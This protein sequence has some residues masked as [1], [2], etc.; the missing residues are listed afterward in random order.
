V[1]RLTGISIAICA[2][3][4]ASC[5]GRTTP[6]ESSAFGARRTTVN[7]HD[8]GTCRLVGQADAARLFHA[9]AA[10]WSVEQPPVMPGMSYCLWQAHSTHGAV[11]GATDYNL[12]VGVIKDSALD[13]YADASRIPGFR[14]FITV[15]VTPSPLAGVGDKAIFEHTNDTT[16]GVEYIK[17]GNLVLLYYGVGPYT[18]ANLHKAFTQRDPLVRL[19]QLAASR[20]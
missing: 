19:S 2:L 3:I 4:M 13:G 20:T 9:P 11:P 17:H 7:S 10:P 16:I 1:R 6:T 14:Q 8:A 15:G 5:G 12:V 18:A